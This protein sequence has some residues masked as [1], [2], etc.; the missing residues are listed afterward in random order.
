MVVAADLLVEIF[1]IYSIPSRAYFQGQILLL[2]L[3]AALD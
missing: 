2:E 3:I 1:I